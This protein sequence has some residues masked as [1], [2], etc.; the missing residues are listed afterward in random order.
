MSDVQFEEDFSSK[1]G[2]NGRP[3]SRL[4]KWVL[5]TGLVKSQ[6]Q[7]NVVLV[8]IA[9]IFFALSIYFFAGAL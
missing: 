9:L 3:T 4:T 1:E 8:L 6:K 5:K 2:E 7:A